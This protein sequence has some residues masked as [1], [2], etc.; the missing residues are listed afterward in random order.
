MTSVPSDGTYI[1]VNVY[2]KAIVYRIDSWHKKSKHINL[3]PQKKQSR[4]VLKAN[5]STQRQGGK[6]VKRE[7]RF[8]AI[9]PD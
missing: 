4:W 7:G 3:H 9:Y 1:H 6:E 5:Q 8:T 2:D